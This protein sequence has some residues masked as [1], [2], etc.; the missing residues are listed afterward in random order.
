MVHVGGE[1]QVDIVKMDCTSDG[2]LATL[3]R[4]GG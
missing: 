4:D 2:E 3:M 1:L